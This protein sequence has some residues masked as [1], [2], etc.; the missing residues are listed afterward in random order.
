MM[1]IYEWYRDLSKS[2]R[3]IEIRCACPHI[4]MNTR[5]A[6]I[7]GRNLMGCLSSQRKRT[8]NKS[9]LLSV[10]RGFRAVLQSIQYTDTHMLALG[11]LRLHGRAGT[12][13]PWMHA[14]LESAMGTRKSD[15]RKSEPRQEMYIHE[16]IECDKTR[17]IVCDVHYTRIY[18]IADTRDERRTRWNWM[19]QA[20][21]ENWYIR[22]EWLSVC[23]CVVYCVL[24]LIS[25]CTCTARRTMPHA[26]EK[27]LVCIIY[28]TNTQKVIK[29]QS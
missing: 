28:W 13:T 21:C 26:E 25:S 6:K 14:L 17:L 8:E 16:E 18:Q 23:V 15:M 24:Y 22:L 20:K 19:D 9:S 7:P 27:K 4:G 29:I 10:W 1:L 2:V 11:S 3:I 12:I 5:R